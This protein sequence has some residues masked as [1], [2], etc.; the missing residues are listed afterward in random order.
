MQNSKLFSVSD[1]K[2]WDY[3]CMAGEWGT[4]MINRGSVKGK[5]ATRMEKD[6]T[7]RCPSGS[8]PGSILFF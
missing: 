3:P 5:R 1:E 2:A 6:S 4:K 8:T 7:P